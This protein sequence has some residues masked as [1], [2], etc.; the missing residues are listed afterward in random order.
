MKVCQNCK[1]EYEDE[2]SFCGRCGMALV[3]EEKNLFCPYCGKKLSGEYAF[4]PY[5]GKNLQNTCSQDFQNTEII[6]Q[7]GSL[8][9]SRANEIQEIIKPVHGEDVITADKTSSSENNDSHPVLRM[10]GSL[11][12][13][14]LALLSLGMVHSVIKEA[15]RGNPA[16]RTRPEGFT[17]QIITSLV[18]AF[19]LFMAFGMLFHII[20][21]ES[22]QYILCAIVYLLASV[23][24]FNLLDMIGVGVSL[25]VG[26]YLL[27]KYK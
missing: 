13:G 16:L 15:T 27:F 8:I 14:V 2:V 18:I 19:L 7:S 9:E 23:I 20:Q 4:C 24:L 3:R 26:I 22:G 10:F 12:C 11:I 1:L 25:I 5:C 21:K 6:P 17:P